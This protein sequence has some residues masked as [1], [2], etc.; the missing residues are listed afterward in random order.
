[1]AQQRVVN[2]HHE[3]VEYVNIGIV[4][5]NKGIISDENGYFSL[6][7]LGAKPTDSIYF[8]HLSYQHKVLAHSDVKKEVQLTEAVINLPTTT[9]TM[10]KPKIRDVKSKGV[11]TP[12][13]LYGEMK[14]YF[15]Q[16]GGIL[17]E[18]GDF[19]T[20]ANDTQLTEFSIEV[21]ESTFYMAVLRVVVYQTDKE[22]KTFTPLIKEPIYINLFASDKPQTFTHKLSVLAPKGELWVGIQFVEMR[23]K[24]DATLTFNA[25]TNTCWLRFPD[26][27]IRKVN[28]GF[29]IPFVVKGYDIIKQ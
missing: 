26:N 20:L 27:T 1:M 10:K 9:L 29:G 23:G 25:T 4:G 8:S 18:L 5:T 2:K 3:P 21:K 16:E 6:E 12:F 19:I 14:Q 15:Q 24:D 7:K 13:T 17:S 22:H 28:L 11:T